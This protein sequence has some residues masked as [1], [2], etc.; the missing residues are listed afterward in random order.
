MNLKKER[1]I[2]YGV[3]C[4]LF[5]VGLVCYAALPVEQPKDPIRIVFKSNAGNVLFDM[6]TH[7]SPEDYGFECID[8]HHE[9]EDPDERPTACGECHKIDKEESEGEINREAA[10]HDQCKLCHE[11][12]GTGPLDCFECHAY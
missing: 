12:S 3:V 4:I 1:M 8:C 2:A 6:K 5:L 9:L 7:N 11:D 10:F